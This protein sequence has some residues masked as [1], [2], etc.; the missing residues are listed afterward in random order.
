MPTPRL[1]VDVARETIRLVNNHNGSIREAA[2][3]AGIDKTTLRSRVKAAARYYDLRPGDDV[4]G[5][6]Q[7][8]DERTPEVT[9]L[10]AQV[11]HLRKQ[12]D[13]VEQRN[14][15]TEEVRAAIFG[16]SEIPVDPPTWTL[17]TRGISRTASCPHAHWS[18]WHLGETVVAAEVNGI[19][20][21]N[22]R[23]A[24]RR[25]RRLVERTIDLCFNHMVNP[26]YPGVVIG[27]GG[28]M[29]SGEIHDELAQT[30]DEDLLPVVL[31]AV[32]WIC[33]ALKAMA[34]RFGRVFVPCA[35]GNHG[36]NT[37]K[38]QHKRFLYKNFDWLIYSL[39]E[40]HFKDICDA[41]VQFYIPASN[42]PLYRIY[43]HR[44]LMLHGHDLGVRGGDGII[45]AIGPITRGRIKVGAQMAQIGRHFDTL[46]NGHWHQYIALKHLIVNNSLKGPDEFSS[47][48]RFSPSTPSQALWFTHPQYGIIAN[49][50]VFVEDPIE[51]K[52]MEWVSWAA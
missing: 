46:I 2:D 38:I 43:N 32:E 14:L 28:D 18:D 45:G 41:R 26:H 52:E 16:L 6:V 44:Y 51:A 49:W 37:H 19:N 4:G 23:I 25:V 13:S 17:D 20:E 35:A 8:A 27:L 1:S 40:K 10:R 29:V 33:A 39:C 22:M 50:E 7:I 48:G 31:K 12:I 30:N 15:S 3:A 36:R 24:E 5:D 42:E 21:F 34:D 47:K 11:A 9:R